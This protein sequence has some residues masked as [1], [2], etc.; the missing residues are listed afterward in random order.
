MKRILLIEY[1]PFQPAH[2][3]ISLGYIA[4]FA[5]KQGIETDILNLGMNSQMSV[6]RFT[7][8]LQRF[9]PQVIGFSAYQRNMFLIK[10][11]AALCKTLLPESIIAIGGPQATFMPTEALRQLPAIDL[12][13]RGEGET[14]F[15]ELAK[16]LGESQGAAVIPG[17]S[18]QGADGSLWDGP[19]LDFEENLDEFPSPYLS[20]VLDLK[21]IDE[22]LLLASRGCPY[23]CSFCYTPQAFGKK[24][25]CHSMERVVEEVSWIAGRGVNRFWFADP[26]FTFYAERVHQFLDTLLERDLKVELWLETRVDLVEQGLLKK[27]N[28]AGVH[29]IA[30]GLE[31][32]SEHIRKMIRKPLDLEQVERAIRLSQEA[33]LEVELFSQYGLPGESFRDAVNTLE[34][35]KRNKVNIRGNTNPQQMQIYFGT[36]IQREPERFGIHP[37]PESFPPY[38]SIGSRYDTDWMSV[39]DIQ[40][41]S[42]LWMEASHDGGKHTVS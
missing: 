33:G 25:R 40:H 34:F 35:V 15:L 1:N 38:L 9:R 42:R 24:I 32:A 3:P 10:G 11:W 39:D 29:T 23:R 7:R 4:A 28:R 41:V 8:Y 31:S 6:G 37:F 12:I 18:G 16:G 2:T 26:S 13:C 19:S 36:E 17:W 14:A 20:G 30:Y 21:G 27:M 5:E 22:A